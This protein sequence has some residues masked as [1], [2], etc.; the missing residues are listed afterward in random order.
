MVDSAHM[1]QAAF[2]NRVPRAATECAVKYRA[3]VCRARGFAVPVLSPDSVTVRQIG[4][5]TESCLNRSSRI[6]PSGF[7][8]APAPLADRELRKSATQASR[9]APIKSQDPAS[10]SHFGAGPAGTAFADCYQPMEKKATRNVTQGDR[11]GAAGHRPVLFGEI[12]LDEFPDG[13]VPGGAPLNVASHLAAFGFNPLVVSRVG[14]DGPGA[15]V[16]G[17]MAERGLDTTG[18]QL[19]PVNPT[20]QVGITLEGSSNFFDFPER[21]AFDYIEPGT[22]R[23]LAS[24]A[25]PAVFYW[26]TLAQRHEPSRSAVASALEAVRCLAF[27]DANL[28]A[29]WYDVGTIVRSLRAADVVKLSLGELDTISAL[30]EVDDLPATAR[31]RGLVETYCLKSLVVTDGS[32]EMWLVTDDGRYFETRVEPLDFVVDT[33]GAGDAV[34]AALIAGELLAWTPDVTLGRAVALARAVCQIRGAAPT[35]G[36]FYE[37]FLREW[38]CL[39]N[40]SGAF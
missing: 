31:A 22:A 14:D 35:S 11:S 30:L 8:P 1:H 10:G 9:I 3:R 15:E 25:N 33:V 36:A 2:A 16:I 5:P 12:L 6:D 40:S 26:G 34:S 32:N 4:L 23:R 27:L 38:H 7:D 13:A 39:T 24:A 18:I 21:Q 28:R 29:P 20:G 37:P 19:D 17:A